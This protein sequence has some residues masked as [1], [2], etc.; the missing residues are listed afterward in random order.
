MAQFNLDTY[1]ER[2]WLA[3]RMLASKA[4]RSV[5]FLTINP[6]L[7]GDSEILAPDWVTKMLVEFLILGVEH[8]TIYH[9]MTHQLK[10]RVQQFLT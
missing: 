8:L 6:Q 9:L 5:Y 3:Q 1:Q 10:V 4:Q 2:C 7:V